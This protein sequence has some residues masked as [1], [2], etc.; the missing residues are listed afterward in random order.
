MAYTGVG[1]KEGVSGGTPLSAENLNK[2]DNAIKNLDGNRVVI[3]GTGED[4]SVQR[5]SGGD[6]T[7][8]LANTV[9]N[10]TSQI[11]SLSNKIDTYH[12]WKEIPNFEKFSCTELR[13]RISKKFTLN[14]KDVHELFIL[15]SCGNIHLCVEGAPINN[16]YWNNNNY[17]GVL[18]VNFY[19]VTDGII[20]DVTCYKIG[21]LDTVNSRSEIIS[22]YYR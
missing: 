21:A 3:G 6:A 22:C 2:M 16:T 17:N 13:T 20:I 10:H 8:A 7:D 14:P 1:W 15:S 19:K 9:A 5:Y 4:I 12:T 11:T 18:E